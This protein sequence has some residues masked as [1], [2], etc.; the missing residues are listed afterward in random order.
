MPD[1]NV[2][3]SFLDVFGRPNRITACEC[4]RTDDPALGQALELVNSK[5]FQRKLSDKTGYVEK[6]VTNGS[7]H[8]NNVREVFLRVLARPPEPA[9]HSAAI[10]FLK[11]E[12]DQSEAYRS[13]LWSLL[14]T[15]EFLFNR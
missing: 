13:L 2:P 1:E 6:L 11:S 8:D 12:A 5:E 7:S 9:E 15:N 3:I 14:V 10:E 4:E